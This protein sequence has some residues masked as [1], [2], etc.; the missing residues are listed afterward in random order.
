M[1]IS[2]D[3]KRFIKFA[4]AGNFIEKEGD[5]WCVRCALGNAKRDFSKAHPKYDRQDLEE[6]RQVFMNDYSELPE[7]KP[8]VEAR[9][10][11]ADLA[12]ENM[13]LLFKTKKEAIRFML[14]AV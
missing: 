8:L 4:A 6:V 2:K 14:E 1:R 13:E 9:N 3:T 10:Y 12:G 5:K 11:L 7:D